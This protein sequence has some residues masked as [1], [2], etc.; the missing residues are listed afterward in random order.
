MSTIFAAAESRPLPLRCRPDVRAVEQRL[1]GERMW[2]LKDPASLKYYHL[3]EEERFLLEQLDGHTSLEQMRSRFEARFTPQRMG[4][5]QLHGFIGMLHSEGLLL[6]DTGGQADVLLGRRREQERRERWA[7]AAGVLAIRFRGVDPGRLLDWLYPRCRWIFSPAAGTA[8]LALALAALMLVAVHWQAVAARLPEFEQFLGGR[9]LLWLAVTIAAVKVLHELGH[10]LALK[11]LGGQCHEI[12]PMLLLFT[13][14]LYCNTTDAW[15]LPGK[16]QRAAVAAA[17]IGVEIV[18]AA[19]A[20]FLWWWSLPGLFNSLCLDV[21]VVCSAS[22]LIFN[23]N[24]LLRYDGYYLLADVVEMPNLAQRAAET[25]H[26]G[27]ANWFFGLPI[28]S[29]RLYRRSEHRGVLT[30]YWL[31][32]TAYRLFVMVAILWALHK[33][34]SPHRLGAL[35]GFLAVA[36]LGGLMAMPGLRIVRFLGDPRWRDRVNLRQFAR[37]GT[38][39][40]LILLGLA[41]IPLPARVLAPAVVRPTDA[42]RVYITVP[43]FVVETKRPGDGVAAGAEIARLRNPEI[44]MAVERARG[45]RDLQRLHVEI[46]KR[47]A[48]RSTK[49]AEELPAAEADLADREKRLDERRIDERRLTITAPRAGVVLAPP[50]HNTAL[51]SAALEAWQGSPL[52]ARNRGAYLHT[53]T[54]VCL[55]GDPAKLE[56]VALVDQY[57]VDFV[58]PGERVSLAADLYPGSRFEG[59]VVELSPARVDELPK[60]LLSIGELPH[61]TDATGQKTPL[62]KIYQARIALD[63]P[64]APLLIGAAGTASIHVAGRS[65]AA[66]WARF[67]SSTF[68]LEW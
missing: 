13:P 49:A 59:R 11:H 25:V 39:A 6:G 32:S 21:M 29:D 8:M 63:S 9:N 23:G 51:S 28:P 54:L 48:I 41:F 58:R 18:L 31:L 16:W 22:T 17:G 15:M 68:R 37:R 2:T 46:L 27:L 61:R 10:A 52:D 35:V 5:P 62:G 1:C 53:G 56:A 36:S 34:L 4:L 44:T 66:R 45:E 55:V 64:S 14:C 60:E 3:S 19:I 12:G 38:F 24:P 40:A 7:R 42:R 65:L 47:R 50:T 33:L 43:G 57:D 26:R 67:V 30:A 20:A